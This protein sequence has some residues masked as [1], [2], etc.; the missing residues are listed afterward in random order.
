MRWC[1]S[2]LCYVIWQTQHS[3]EF[4]LRCKRKTDLVR[5][6]CIA[7]PS[8]NCDIIIKALS[9]LGKK[10]IFHFQTLACSFSNCSSPGWKIVSGQQVKFWKDFNNEALPDRSSL[11]VVLFSPCQTQWSWR[12]FPVGFLSFCRDG[13]TQSHL[14]RFYSIISLNE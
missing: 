5:K 14:K 13:A 1:L 2:P 7:A 6:K 4:G 10:N 11:H 3:G 8:T 9:K 12:P